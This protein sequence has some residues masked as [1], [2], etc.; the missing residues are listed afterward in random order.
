[1]PDTRSRSATPRARSSGFDLLSVAGI[2]I[3]IDYSWVET[4]FF[5]DNQ[6]ITAKFGF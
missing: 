1:M 6:Y 2:R 3:S 5:D 4:E